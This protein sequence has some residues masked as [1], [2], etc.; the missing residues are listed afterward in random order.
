MSEINWQD[1]LNI[2]TLK[3][4]DTGIT[5]EV[6]SDVDNGFKICYNAN[7]L[8][9]LIIRNR[10]LSCERQQT[11]KLVDIWSVFVPIYCRYLLGRC[12]QSLITRNT[13]L[14]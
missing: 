2:L 10:Y 13:N 5:G 9:T 6:S 3:G 7:R 12:Y 1:F 8:V 4:L 11:L 14:T